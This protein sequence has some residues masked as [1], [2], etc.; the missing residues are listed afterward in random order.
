MDKTVLCYL[1]RNDKYLMLF[2]NKEKDDINFGKWLGIGGHIEKNETKEQAIVRE[3]KEETGL[4]LLSFQYRGELFFKDDDYEEMIYIFTSD[5]FKGDL[6]ECDEGTLEYVQKDKIMSLN[7]WEGDKV[8]LPK[9]LN[10][11]EHI[12][13]NVYYIKGKLV[14][15]EE[16]PNED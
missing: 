16:R 10:T 3:V 5:D 9:L 15:V 11:S 13:L 12:S 4:D 8:F 14:R 1:K 6:K 7:M 2:R